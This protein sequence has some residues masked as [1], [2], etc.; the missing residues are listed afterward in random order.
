MLYE[1]ITSSNTNG[2]TIDVRLGSTIGPI[3]GTAT[4]K[5]TGGWQNWTTVSCDIN[6]ASEVKDL[7]FMF[8]GGN[9]YVITSYSIHYTKLYDQV[10][11]HSTNCNKHYKYQQ[12]K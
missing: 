9:G 5:N 11:F 2:G 3:V 10:R 12:N 7:Y 8:K 1:V 6:G 4:V